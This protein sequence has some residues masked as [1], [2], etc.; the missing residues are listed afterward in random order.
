MTTNKRV[1]ES[2]PAHI[3]PHAVTLQTARY[4][5]QEGLL[6]VAPEKGAKMAVTKGPAVWLRDGRLHVTPG[7]WDAD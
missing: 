6:S 7:A 3:P 4:A 1:G 2:M 5:V